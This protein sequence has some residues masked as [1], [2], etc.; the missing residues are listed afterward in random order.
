MGR[1]RPPPLQPA[2]PPATVQETTTPIANVRAIEDTYAVNIAAEVA[3]AEPLFVRVGSGRGARY[4]LDDGH[5][6]GER[7]RPRVKNGRPK[8]E[9]AR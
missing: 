5:T 9:P 3:T 6:P 2:S 8:Y 7:Y 1:P 4:R